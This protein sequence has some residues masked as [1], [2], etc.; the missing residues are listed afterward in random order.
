MERYY[1]SKKEPTRRSA[2]SV[3]LVTLFFIGCIFTVFLLKG[4][5]N[6]L[7]DELVDQLAREREVTETN[8]NLK[9]DLA[10]I[11][12]GRY[13]EYKVKERL[14]LKKPKEEEVLVLR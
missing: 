9:M 7:R 8:N 6:Q 11:T 1:I 12:R 14:G 13:L 5:N 3:F 2:R 4:A 10:V